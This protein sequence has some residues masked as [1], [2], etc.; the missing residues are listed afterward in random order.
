MRNVTL[1]FL[2]ESDM[3]LRYVS[4]IRILNARL[5]KRRFILES[6]IL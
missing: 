5:A 1:R 4:H 3:F 6:F 2:H